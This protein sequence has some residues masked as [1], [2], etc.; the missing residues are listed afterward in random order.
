MP[1]NASPP[2]WA[3]LPG[4]ARTPRFSTLPRRSQRFTCTE[5]KDLPRVTALKGRK[6]PFRV[7]PSVWMKVVFPVYDVAVLQEALVA[8]PALEIDSRRVGSP[9]PDQTQGGP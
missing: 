6:F 9:R 3:A 4:T 2:L 8:V 1:G 5:V 7:F